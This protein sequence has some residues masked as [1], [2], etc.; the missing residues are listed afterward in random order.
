MGVIHWTEITSF[1]NIRKF[2]DAYPKMLNG[3]ATI[4]Y[5]A[6]VK[7]HGTNSGIQIHKDAVIAQSRTAELVG[8]ADNNGFAKWVETNKEKWAAIA[9]DTDEEFVIFGEWA[10]PGIQ[11]GVAVNKIPN[12]AF[13]VFAAQHLSSEDDTL[14]VEPYLLQELVKGIP[15]T[16]VLPWYN[17][18][19]E[20]DWSKSDKELSLITDHINEWVNEVEKNDPWVENTF[21]IKGTGEGIVLYP[22]SKEHLGLKNFKNFVFKAKG[23]KHKNV[24][25]AAPAQVNPEIAANIDQ[26]VDMVLTD[27]RLEQGAGGL[28][29]MKL[30]GKFLSWIAADVQKETKAELDASGLN[31]AAVNKAISNKARTWYI[32]KCKI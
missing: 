31:W 27:A 6:K 19:I 11:R 24:K 2:I 18:P 15:D 28:Y 8:G 5:R 3:N 21:G 1:H 10:G 23:E 12:K 30:M 20:V 9:N 32:C 4:T 16:Y 13:V 22:T 26:F 7:L 17:T 29:D 25:T 14:I